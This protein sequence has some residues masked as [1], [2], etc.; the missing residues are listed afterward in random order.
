MTPTYYPRTPHRPPAPDPLP[1]ARRRLLLLERCL[2]LPRD[3]CFPGCEEMHAEAF[4]RLE[5]ERAKLSAL[6]AKEAR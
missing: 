5:Q 4:G 1:W 6:L 2:S 3:R